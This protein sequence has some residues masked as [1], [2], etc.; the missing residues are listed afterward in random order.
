MCGN[1]YFSFYDY[2]IL[3]SEGSPNVKKLFWKNRILK[4]YNSTQGILI[5]NETGEKLYV[6]VIGTTG[7]MF[8]REFSA[9][10]QAVY[11]TLNVFSGMKPIHIYDPRNAAKERVW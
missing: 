5:N 1:D 8:M 7:G 3:D 4:Q 2:F 11:K 6:T 10:E 9:F